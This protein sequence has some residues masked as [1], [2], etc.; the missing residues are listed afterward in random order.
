[1]KEKL[2][3]VTTELNKLTQ[4]VS[5]SAEMEEEVQDLEQKLQLAYSKSEEQVRAMHVATKSIGYLS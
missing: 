4:K 1:V 5:K 3:E 2:A